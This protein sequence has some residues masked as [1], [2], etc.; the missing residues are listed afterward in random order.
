M[1]TTSISSIF[2]VLGDPGLLL[3]NVVYAMHGLVIQA[4]FYHYTIYL[5]Y[6]I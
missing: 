1:S 4:A 2:D 5:T 3:I 6:Y